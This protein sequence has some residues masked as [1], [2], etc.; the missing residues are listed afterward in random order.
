MKKQ[1]IRYLALGLA[2]LFAVM[3]LFLMMAPGLTFT[4]F[5]LT[6]TDSVYA[7]LSYD[8]VVQPGVLVALL[9]VSFSVAILVALVVM[10]LIKVNFKFGW[11]LSLFV[12]LLLLTA[13]ILFFLIKS[14]VGAEG[15][16]VVHIGAGAV[17]SGIFSLFGALASA[18]YGVMAK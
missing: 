4:A 8:E 15:S 2:A 7:V 12:A 3:V 9:F 10:K 1:T 5:G 16:S 13:G 11:L 17:T 18:S 14:L 6:A